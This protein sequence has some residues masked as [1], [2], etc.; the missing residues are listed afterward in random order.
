VRDGA[1]IQLIPS[2]DGSLFS[3]D[4]EKIEPLPVSAD[5][6]LSSSFKV[7]EDSVITGGKETRIYGLDVQT[8]KVRV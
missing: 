3:F 5:T 8:G 1:K 6:L 2:L 4:G 7:S